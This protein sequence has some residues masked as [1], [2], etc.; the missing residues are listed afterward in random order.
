MARFSELPGFSRLLSQVHIV[1]ATGPSSRLST[2]LRRLGFPT[3]KETVDFLASLRINHLAP[4]H[5]DVTRQVA[6]N[7]TLRRRMRGIPVDEFMLDLLG[8]EEVR[9]LL[10]RGF[11]KR[12]SLLVHQQE[13][14]WWA[15]EHFN[16]ALVM[17]T[18]QP[19]RITSPNQLLQAGIQARTRGS[20]Q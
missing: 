15:A 3:T 6:T 17:N 1:P 20:G 9:R 18:M 7:P 5:L 12:Y 19:R 2:A 10:E 13:E 4:L 16:R 11:F 8:F 14:L